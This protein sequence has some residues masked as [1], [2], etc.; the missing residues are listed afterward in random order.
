MLDTYSYFVHFGLRL[1][2]YNFQNSEFYKHGRHM[3]IEKE[4]IDNNIKCEVKYDRPTRPQ[5]YG[6]REKEKNIFKVCR[7]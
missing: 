6:F 5:I 3:Y 7:R 4:L 1:C 2:T